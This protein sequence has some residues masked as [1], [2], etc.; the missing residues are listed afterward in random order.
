MPPEFLADESRKRVAASLV[1]VTFQF[2]VAR[3]GDPIADPTLAWPDDRPVI[4][5]GRV[6]IDA[7]EPGAGGAC[8]RMTF[9]PLVLLEGLAPSSDPVLLARPAPYAISLG[10]RLGETRP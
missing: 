5:A 4:N 2:R 6:V 1:A 10:R 9:N 3:A 7:V 8:E